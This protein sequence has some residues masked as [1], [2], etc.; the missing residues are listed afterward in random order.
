MLEKKLKEARQ[1]KG[2]TQAELADALG[3]TQQGVARWESGKS[4]PNVETLITLAD[5]FEMSTDSLLG[6]DGKKNLFFN[7]EEKKLVAGYRTL[8]KAKRQTLCNML[9]FLTAPQGI[10]MGTVVQKNKSG[11]N[12]YAGTEI[13]LF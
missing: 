13:A 4:K 12:R 8:D 10:S 6:R 5:F 2:I 3:I 7:D 9:A 1:S 11:H